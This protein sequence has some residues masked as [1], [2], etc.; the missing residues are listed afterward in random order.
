M[1]H[2]SMVSILSR[3]NLRFRGKFTSLV[4]HRWVEVW[5]D[6]G[7]IQTQAHPA[8]QP[9]QVPHLV[10]PRKNKLPVLVWVRRYRTHL[11]AYGNPPVMGSRMVQND[12]LMF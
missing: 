8:P 11:M 4:Q 5:R 1:V 3:W 9:A 12:R 2:G 7:R 6:G 10:L